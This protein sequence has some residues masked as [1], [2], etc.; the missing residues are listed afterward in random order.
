LE[1]IR[2]VLTLFSVSEFSFGQNQTAGRHC[3]DRPARSRRNVSLAKLTFMLSTAPR[4][5]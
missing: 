2:A 3:A 5:V 1:K 4:R